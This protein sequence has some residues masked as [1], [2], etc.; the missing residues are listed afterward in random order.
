MC[1]SD[2]VCTV[3]VATHPRA[4]GETRTHF[5]DWLRHLRW[6]DPGR[7][8]V[9]LAVNE[10]VT[11]AVEHSGHQQIPA[12]ATPAASGAAG[13]P[14]R[15][16]SPAAGRLDRRDR[17]RCPD[18]AGPGRAA[19]AGAGVRYRPVAHSAGRPR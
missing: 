5:R 7:E 2:T 11:N 19:V 1:R 10:A 8:D 14:A 18:R 17:T 3:A 13:A 15:T 4:V 16:G 9:L 12:T 6:P